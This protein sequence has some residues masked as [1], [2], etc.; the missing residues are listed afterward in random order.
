[1]YIFRRWEEPGTLLL[2]DTLISNSGTG[3]RLSQGVRPRY[4]QPQVRV[5]ELRGLDGAGRTRGLCLFPRLHDRIDRLL[6]L[7]GPGRWRRPAGREPDMGVVRA[8]AR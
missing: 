2:I 3:N 6:G 7:A 8:D 5:V 1:M 4:P